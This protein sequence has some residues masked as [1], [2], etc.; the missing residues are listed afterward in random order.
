MG[1]HSLVGERPIGSDARRTATERQPGARG[2]GR[3]WR[4]P[5][6]SACPSSAAPSAEKTATPNRPEQKIARA[7]A[8]RRRITSFGAEMP[9]S[10]PQ[11][12]PTSPLDRRARPS[13]RSAASPSTDPEPSALQPRRPLL[14]RMSECAGIV[15]AAA[16]VATLAVTVAIA[17]GWVGSSSTT[18]VACLPSTLVC[19]PSN[20]TPPHG[21]LPLEPNV[22]WLSVRPPCSLRRECAARRRAR[23][24]ARPQRGSSPTTWHRCGRRQKPV[25]VFSR[26]RSKASCSRAQ[27]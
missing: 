23:G 12:K 6:G 4:R 24:R 20:A 25:G 16:A 14:T 22:P 26:R 18:V 9:P 15:G 3:V 17:F 11:R 27:P 8:F 1:A 10:R 7:T 13:L 5:R 21:P 19:E 2:S